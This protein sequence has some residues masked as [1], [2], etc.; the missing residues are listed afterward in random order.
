MA[1]P[2]TTR[3]QYSRPHNDRQNDLTD[4]EW[5]LIEPLIPRQGRMGRPRATDLRRVFDAIQYM[6]SSGCQW[7]LI[8]P[9]Y[10]P[11]STVQN[12][13]YAWR[14]DGTLERMLD[15]LRAQ[16]RV[17]ARRK[18]EPTAAIIDSQSVKTTES[19]GP[20][21]YDGGKKIKG[22]KRHI[23]VDVEGFPIAIVVHEASVQDRDGAPVVIR[24]MLE[25][26][27]TVIRLW[28]DGGYQ[29]PKLAS[30]LQEMGLAELVEI[31]NKPK[32]S[33]GFT[34]IPRRWVVERTFAWMSRCRRLAKD[35]ERTLESS[36]AWVQLAA[37]R[38][39]M[40]RIARETSA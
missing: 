11:F 27:P 39:L 8:P 36:L 12:H 16:A 18:E 32:E 19:G 3:A 1:W 17:Q 24:A 37:C 2:E 10:P 21:G 35:F 23:A 22:R 25:K 14:N 7:R 30:T 13:F 20:R 29:G 28:A 40:R 33:K 6:L 26:A 5:A 38:F 4:P 15:A 31:V 9:C 34:V